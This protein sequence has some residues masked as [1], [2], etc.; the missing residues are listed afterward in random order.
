MRR[1]TWKC[2]NCGDVLHQQLDTKPY[3]L[4]CPKRH[5]FDIA[6]QGYVN[7]LLPQKRGAM[8]PGDSADMVRARTLFLGGGYYVAFS[9]GVNAAVTDILRKTGAPSPVIADAGCGEGYYTNRLCAH[10]LN[11]GFDAAC[12]GFDLSK[13][14]VAHAAKTA[15]AAALSDRLSFSV[16]SL[17]EMPLADASV[18]GIINLFAPTADAEFA[19]VLQPRGFLLIAVPA[20]RHL[21]G[22]KAA[23]YDT[24]YENEIRRDALP[25]FTLTEIREIRNTVTVCGNNHIKALF[26][27]TP[28]YWKT[29]PADAAKLDM[30]QALETEIAFDLLI[31][32]KEGA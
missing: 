23:V 22:L 3:T 16:A 28:Y 11:G 9:D 12:V 5:A 30:L 18:S 19:R 4:T 24:P 21:W 10:L 26:S 6:K 25:H 8:P 31:Y 2:P 32:R 29:S 7:L 14:A 1:I 13:D 27:M 15:K 17:F 20:E